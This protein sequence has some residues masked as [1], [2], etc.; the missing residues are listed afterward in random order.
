MSLECGV[1]FVCRAATP[2]TVEETT[3]GRDHPCIE[4][5]VVRIDS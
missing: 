2:A 1:Q 4:S 5:G 3:A